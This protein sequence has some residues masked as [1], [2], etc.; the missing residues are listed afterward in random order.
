MKILPNCTCLYFNSLQNANKLSEDI[1]IQKLIHN[2]KSFC[3]AE[4]RESIIND[5]NIIDKV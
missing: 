5:T 2:T 3:M 4:G 1:R